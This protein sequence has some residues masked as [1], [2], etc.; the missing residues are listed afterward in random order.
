MTWEN[1]FAQRGQSIISELPPNLSTLPEAKAEMGELGFE[2][3]DCLGTHFVHMT[4][5]F[6]AGRMKIKGCILWKKHTSH[7]GWW[8]LLSSTAPSSSVSHE[9]TAPPWLY[10]GRVPH[11]SGFF[12]SVTSDKLL[13]CLKIYSTSWKIFEILQ[14]FHTSKLEAQLDG[15]ES[16]A[17]DQTSE[18]RC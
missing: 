8:Q 18:R 17:Q 13:L 11:S 2:L 16:Q 14:L 12:H 15:Q 9:A 1:L 7:G 4:A 6:R 3:W 5:E 10:Q